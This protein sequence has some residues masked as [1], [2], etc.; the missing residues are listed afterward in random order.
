MNYLTAP[1]FL[2]GMALC[3]SLIMAIGPQN[4]HVMRMGLLRQHLWL[5]V[6]VCIFTD[7]VLIALG[8]AGL[9]QLGGLSDKLLGAMTGAGAVVLMG[10]GA[11]AFKRFLQPSATVLADNPA[12]PGGGAAAV[13]RRQAMGAALAF[14]WV[15]PH[16]WLDNAVLMGTAALAHAPPED[17]VFGIGAA[18]GSLLWFSALGL[19]MACLGRHLDSPAVWR[20]LDA[21]VALMM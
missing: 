4:A 6:A 11:Q 12:A 17:L 3:L 9:A 15:N 14:S 7:I 8:V 10:Y 19:A 20:A 16:A 18:T 21:L 5:T 1:A 2:A 13:S